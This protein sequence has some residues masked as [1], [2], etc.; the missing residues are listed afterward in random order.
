MGLGKRYL[1]MGIVSGKK[2][3][4]LLVGASGGVGS[5]LLEYLSSRTSL[6]CIPTY[7]RNRPTTDR[8][9]WIQY[10]SNDFDS[11]RAMLEE[12]S[13][14][15]DLS[16]VIDATGSFFA[17]RLQNSSPIEIG[18]VI[19]TN[20][21]APL[22]LAKSAQEFMLYGG[23]MIFMSSIVSTMQLMGSSIYA[24]SKAGL[25]RGILSLSSEF[26]QSG[27]GICGIRLGYM[28]YGMTYKIN[29]RV[30]QEILKELP[31]EKFIEI[32]VL[33]DK[34]LQILDSQCG[35][36]NGMIYEIK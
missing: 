26:S 29:E 33:G 34:I 31:E 21:I 7:N 12:V 16:L 25:E 27:H 18:E 9:T 2:S 14:N 20:L 15:Y 6:V 19:S 36:I 8:F 30:R 28:D 13:E 4:L 32:R 22:I 10:N 23:K 11:T 24:A 35:E 17:S 1:K 3:A 5:A